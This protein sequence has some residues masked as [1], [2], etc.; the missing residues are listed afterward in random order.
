[1]N[2]LSLFISSLGNVCTGTTDLWR[3]ISFYVCIPGEHEQAPALIPDRNERGSDIQ[4]CHLILGIIVVR[5]GPVRGRSLV[6]SV[7]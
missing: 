4:S 2:P 6:P 7:H 3:K 1:M 5:P